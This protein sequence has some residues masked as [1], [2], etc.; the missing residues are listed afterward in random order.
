MS[1]LAE[2][3]IVPMGKGVSVSPVVAR[4]L[5]IVTESGISYKANPMGTVIEGEWDAVM[6]VIRRCHAEV[7]KDA[8]RAI[9]SIKI[10]D[11][12]GAEAR[13]A[14]KLASVE[15]KLGTKLNT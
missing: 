4:V 8:D 15:Q 3:S 12:K 7:M 2:F 14:K 9:T 5:K 10:D 13:M 1:V 11:R 6:D